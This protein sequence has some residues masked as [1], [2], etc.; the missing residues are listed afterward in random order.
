MIS[1]R[2]IGRR[3]GFT[4]IELLVVIAIIALLTAILL[5]SLQAARQ[6]ARN[7]ACRVHMQMASKSMSLYAASSDQYFAGPNT[8][9]L[10]AVDG[11]SY[12][13]NID[14]YP[15]TPTQNFDWV[16]PTLGYTLGLPENQHDRLR[17]IF[18]TQLACPS[19]DQYYQA[20]AG[21]SSFSDAEVQNIQLASYSSPLAFHVVGSAVESSG[22]AVRLTSE[23]QSQLA[24]YV[25]PT[26]YYRPMLSQVGAASDKVYLVE[27][28]RR[29]T[30]SG[31][32]S[33]NTYSY[34]TKGGNF[35]LA[36]PAAPI[37]NDPFWARK[38][39][40]RVF[41]HPGETMNQV[42]FD[43]HVESTPDHTDTKQWDM[44][45]YVP[46]RFKIIAKPP[47]VTST[48]IR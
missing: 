42:F 28:A 21:Q 5:P 45:H 16:S 3:C 38:N 24:R 20:Q 9:G 4:L 29:V 2:R 13:Q 17:E 35:G 19:N 14:T 43:G 10:Q 8:S 31:V 22:R 12:L 46:T 34:Q 48:R 32:I 40:A 6:V 7:V 25:Q 36:G 11:P 26:D 23:D 33:F 37:T 15:T 44:S 30:N 18:N 1:T 39:R 47:R 27:G 41:R